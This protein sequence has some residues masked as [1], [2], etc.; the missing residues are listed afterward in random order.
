MARIF[1][2]H[3]SKDNV[4]ALAISQWLKTNGWGTPYLDIDPTQGLAP[5]EQWRK[6]LTAAAARCARASVRS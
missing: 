2:S 4:P 3:S 5:G 1:I 6:A